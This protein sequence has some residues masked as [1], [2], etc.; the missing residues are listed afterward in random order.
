MGKSKQWIGF[1]I[2]LLFILVPTYTVAASTDPDT[3]KVVKV[4]YFS[5]D[6][7]QEEDSSGAKN[8]YGYRFLQK[9]ANRRISP[10]NMSGI[11]ISPGTR[12]LPC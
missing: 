3:P 12:C 7:Y 1:F 11:R 6:E 10:M 8:G 9:L 4:G 5:L 2:L